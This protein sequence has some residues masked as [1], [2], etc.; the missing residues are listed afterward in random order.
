MDNSAPTALP[1]TGGATA[2][3]A[4]GEAEVELE[5]FLFQ[6]AVLTVRVG[7]TVKFS[8]KDDAR[9]TVTSDTNVFDSGFLAKGDEFRFTF[10]EPGEYP[11][12]CKPHGGP[13]G[14]GMSG[15]IIVV[16]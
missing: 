11:Y 12:Y 1:Q 10:N 6:P 4:V 14:A 9:H 13:G 16:P 7:T 15:T 2:T 8:N 5:D 3:V